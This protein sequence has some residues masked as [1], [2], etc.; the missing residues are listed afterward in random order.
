VGAAYCNTRVLKVLGTGGAFPGEPISTV[1][2]LNSIDARFGLS[3]S[4]RGA[5]VARR[6]GVHGRHVA[7]DLCARHEAPRLGDS[8]A[9]LAARAVRAA[10]RD[11][12]RAVT[13]ITYLVA[14]TATPGTLLP[15]GVAQ[16]AQLL[17]YEGP[18]VELRQACTG[19]ANALVFGAS[20]AGNRERGVVVLV[21]SETGSVYFDP[22][23]AA[24]DDGQLINMLQMGDGAGAIVIDASASRTDATLSAQISGQISGHYVGQLGHDRQPAFGLNAGGSDQ[25]A[26]AA[27]HAEFFHDFAAIRRD[28][29]QLFRAGIKAAAGMGIEVSAVDW[30]IPHQANGRMAELL[31]TALGI[32]SARVFVNAD[33]I[34][35]T[36]SAAIWLALNELRTR[37]KVGER[38]LVLGAEATKFMYGGF[39]YVHG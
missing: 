25:A 6:L 17:D 15:P 4:R 28:G 11:A 29:E 27:A 3:L 18:F 19:F 31:A 30:I 34:G 38:V 22:Q 12:G 36:G 1:Q 13:D 37:L 5:A 10:L 26:T 16:V 8:N 24:E 9:E 39:L 33:R 20:I 35:N 21:G 7:R 23:R 2:L 14:H 32:A